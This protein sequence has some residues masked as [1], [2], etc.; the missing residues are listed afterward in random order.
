MPSEKEMLGRILDRLPPGDSLEQTESRLGE[1]FGIKQRFNAGAERAARVFAER[2]G[3]V[4]IYALG[5]RTEPK[6]VRPL[7]G[8]K[9]PW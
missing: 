1:L 3:C 8:G 5:A 6:F 7:D 2:H 9:M 4:L